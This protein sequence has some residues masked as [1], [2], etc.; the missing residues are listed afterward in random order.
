LH[1]IGKFNAFFSLY[2]VSDFIIVPPLA[3]ILCPQL[4]STMA[5]PALNYAIYYNS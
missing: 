2:Y 3:E 5:A 1:H 4:N